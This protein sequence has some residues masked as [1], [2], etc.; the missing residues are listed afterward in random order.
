MNLG[1]RLL[2]DLASTIEVIFGEDRD[3]IADV[4]A[5][6]RRLIS[7]RDCIVWE[8]SAATFAFTYVSNCAER[9]L[10]YPVERWHQPGFWADVIL[11]PEDREDAVAYCALA[12]AQ[13]RDH[14]FEYRARATD[15]SVRWLY[16]VVRVV[17]GPSGIPSR[18]RGV[19]L[20][21][22]ELK[23]RSGEHLRPAWR[24]FPELRAA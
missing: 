9:V 24:R 19:M 22:D 23:A 8:C 10:G 12:S 13:R 6:A 11:H 1:P 5:R 16:D 14:E 21:I 2:V 18:L 3:P 4:D 17:V 15:G 20:Q 7:D